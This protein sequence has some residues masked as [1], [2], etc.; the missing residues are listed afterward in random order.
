MVHN[1]GEIIVTNCLY[2]ISFRANTETKQLK[3]CLIFEVKGCS[4][5]DKVR[6]INLTDYVSD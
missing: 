6:L 4:G 5:A 3:Q 1:F 2:L